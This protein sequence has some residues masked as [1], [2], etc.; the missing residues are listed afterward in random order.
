MPTKMFAGLIPAL[1]TAAAIWTP[2]AMMKVKSVA[3]V[4]SSPDGPY[5]VRTECHA[6]M[7]AEKSEFIDHVFLGKTDGSHR[8]QLTFGEKS[9]TQPQFSIDGRS[10]YYTSD[11]GAKNQ[12]YRIAVDGGEAEAVTDFKGGVG[13]YQISPDGKWIAFTGR[14]PDAERP[15]TACPFHRPSR[16]TTP[17]SVSASKRKWSRFPGLPMARRSRSSC[18]ISCSGTSPGWRSTSIRQRHR[19][20]R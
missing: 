5:A 14:E 11:R 12:V 13:Q 15:T 8:V 9:S 20:T 2:E 10:V 7:E 1:A 3:G 16:C 18:S 6:V 4:T 17:S 19:E